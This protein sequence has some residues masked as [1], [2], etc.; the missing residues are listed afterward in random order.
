MKKIVVC[1]VDT[2]LRICLLSPFQLQG[3]I[4][5]LRDTH[6]IEKSALEAELDSL[7][8]QLTEAAN[9]L[10]RPAPI[11]MISMLSETTSRSATPADLSDSDRSH[12]ISCSYA[13]SSELKVTQ[14]QLDAVRLENKHLKE[15]VSHNIMAIHLIPICA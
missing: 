5:A 10:L 13:T 6:S 12:N 4:H 14:R 1:I 11:H 3:Q 8:Q 7:R 15:Q 2:V 9:R